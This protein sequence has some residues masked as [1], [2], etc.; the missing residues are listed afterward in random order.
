[1]ELPAY[2]RLVADKMEKVDKEEQMRLILL[3]RDV[4]EDTIE[5]V[6]GSRD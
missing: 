4:L 2:L 1:M 3:L 6:T 5:K